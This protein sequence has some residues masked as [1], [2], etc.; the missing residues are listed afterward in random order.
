MRRI[1]DRYILAE[2]LTNWV[3][4]TLV[5]LFIL[6][7]NQFAR[8]LGEAAAGSLPRD[9]VAGLVMLAGI[10][11]LIT[12]APV[13]LFLAYIM[14]FGRLYRDSEM[15]AMQGC[16]VSRPRLFR[17][18]F[19]VAALLAAL[20]TW[21]AL[22]VDPWAAHEGF[23]VRRT[24]ERD[25][26]FGS[27][28]SG[29]FKLAGGGEGVFYSERL[30]AG[31]RTL[32][33]VFLAKREGREVQIVFAPS[34]R[35]QRDT[36]SGERLLILEDGH[37]YTG[38]PGEAGFTSVAF[39]EHGVPVR[40]DAPDLTAHNRDGIPTPELLSSQ[41]IADRAE[42]QW[43]LTKPVSVLVLTILALPLVR[44]QPR[45][46]RGGKIIA[47]VLA[48][49]IYSNILGAAKVWMVNGTVPEVLGLWWVHG[50]TAAVGVVFMAQQVGFRY[51]LSRALPG[52]RPARTPA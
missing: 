31:G 11:Y 50:L 36:V 30:A 17:P 40:P 39:E 48:Y 16:G 21:M 37:R 26:E 1:L 10:R 28:E 7:A 22:V 18:L 6:M 8:I 51:V 46:G 52:G 24:A 29:R 49:V 2:V 41:D 25:A 9:A 47:A 4:I 14:A 44:A 3:A 42:F 43:R 12:L 32:D 35:Q 15:F 20:M 19:A 38:V 33:T 27:F 34:G 13:G 45:Q 23:V 5:L